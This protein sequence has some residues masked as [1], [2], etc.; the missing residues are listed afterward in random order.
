MTHGN[1]RWFG[2]DRSR[3][4]IHRCDQDRSRELNDDSAPARASLHCSPPLPVIPATRSRDS[5]ARRPGD[6]I[7]RLTCSSFRRL[8]HATHVL[9]IPATRSRD[10]R[11]RHSGDSIRRLMCSSFR[12]LDHATHV[13]VIP[14]TRSR[15]SHARHPGDPIARLTCSSSRRPDRATHVL[16]IPATRSRDSRARHPGERRD[17]CCFSRSGLLRGIRMD[18]TAAEGRPV[19]SL[20]KGGM[21][22]SRDSAPANF[23]GQR[24]AKVVIHF[25][26]A[27]QARDLQQEHTGSRLSPG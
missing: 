5:R 13:L 19:L 20:S 9:V 23:P 11:A 16:V 22:G 21:T 6:S 12:R 24:W 7:A 27:S 8:D 15:D 2:R 4:S 17:P 3:S 1:W 10:S 25:D 26:V 18:R 14:A